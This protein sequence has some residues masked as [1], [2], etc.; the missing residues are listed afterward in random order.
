MTVLAV[1]IVSVTTVMSSSM[2]VSVRTGRRTNAI[3][4]AT[5][6]IEAT[7]AIPYDQIAPASTTTTS[8]ATVKGTTYKVALGIVW[9]AVAGNPQAYKQSVVDVI[10]TDHDGTHDVSQTTKMYPGDKSPSTTTTVQAAG[11]GTP[12]A[13]TALVATVPVDVSGM[14]GVD[15]VWTPPLVSNPA[16]AGWIV[17]WSADSGTTWSTI[18]N[19]VAAQVTT[20]RVSGLSAGTGYQFRVASIAVC[21]ALSAWSPVASATTLTSTQVQCAPGAVAVTP[22]AVTRASGSSS[23]GL[24][25][26][27]VVTLNTTGTCVGFTIRYSPT[28]GDNRVVALVLSGSGVWSATLAGATTAAWDV[29]QHPIDVYDNLGAKRGTAVLTV[30]EHNAKVCA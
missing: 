8:M 5:Q 6:A 20:M 1:G 29:G 28:T 27:P 26:R 21:T 16:I 17:Q 7:R 18:A 23:A 24:S 22:S 25:A 15:V 9:V 30:C 19:N 10:W 2:G 14:T 13:P 11:C 3:N 12:A 4:L